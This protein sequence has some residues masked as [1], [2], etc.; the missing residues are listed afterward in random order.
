MTKNSGCGLLAFAFLVIN[1]SLAC[2]LALAAS[3][4]AGWW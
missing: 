4:G 1:A 2:L 3:C